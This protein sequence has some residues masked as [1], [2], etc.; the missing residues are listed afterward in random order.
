MPL[1]IRKIEASKWRNVKLD[2]VPADNITVSLKTTKNTLSVWLADSPEKINDAVLAIVSNF[3]KADTIDILPI[4]P[5]ELEK[6][7]ISFEMSRG[8]TRYTGF[9]SNHYDLV[10][11][12]YKQLGVIAQIIIDSVNAGNYKRFTRGDIKRLL[13][14]AV[15]SG[16]LNPQELEKGLIEDCGLSPQVQ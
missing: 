11:I 10:N 4:D 12:T 6:K 7:H 16:K 14:Q 2:D 15:Q 13:S 9:S 8:L 1:M 5:L 3:T